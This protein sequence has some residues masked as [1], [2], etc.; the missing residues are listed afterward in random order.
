MN[1]VTYQTYK[2]H[3]ITSDIHF[4]HLNILKYCS[5]TRGMFANVDEM[6]EKLIA[7]WNSDVSADDHVFILGD[8]C[9]GLIEKAPGLISQLKGAKTLVVGNHDRSLLKLPIMS[10]EEGRRSLGFIEVTDYK[11]F[12]IKK[13]GSFVMMHY[14]LS[15]YDGQ[16]K[17]AIHFHGHLHGSPPNIKQ[18]GRIKDVGADTNNLKPYDFEKLVKEMQQM[19][20][21]SINHH[22]NPID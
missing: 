2:K 14:P 3:W 6:N 13:I 19:Q 7:N 15:S 4:G 8:V 1:T 16:N 5:D 12:G 9:M 18:L 21:P 11:C 20:L 22:G 17:G 10:T